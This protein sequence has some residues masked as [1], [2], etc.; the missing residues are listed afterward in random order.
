LQA[1]IFD[2]AHVV[3]GAKTIL[4]AAGVSE[5]CQIVS[6]DFFESVP[7]QGDLY[8]ISRVLLNWDDDQAL[9]LLK[10][11]RAAMGHSAKLLIIDFVLPNQDTTALDLLSSLHLLVLGGRLL[12]TEEEY[13]ALLS[14][15]GF[16]SPRL[17]PT[18]NTL[19]LIEAVPK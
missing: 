17:I 5:R 4:E 12:R 9:K 1:I 13:Y 11:C 19:R 10:N 8:I 6:G 14:A 18:G 15:A 2:Q 7:T 3:T 16:Q